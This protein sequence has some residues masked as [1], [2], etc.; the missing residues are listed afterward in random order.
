M[1]IASKGLLSSTSSSAQSNQKTPE[2]RIIEC[3]SNFTAE[4]IVIEKIKKEYGLTHKKAKSL[5]DSVVDK[6]RISSTQELRDRMILN[7][8]RTLEVFQKALEASLA[9]GDMKGA[10]W[11]SGQIHR[12]GI[13]L[14]RIVLPR[15]GIQVTAKTD[16]NEVIDSAWGKG[17]E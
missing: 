11:L 17:E 15:T 1:S 4:S 2:D 12:I 16:P 7:S 5:Y 9:A 3:I 6:I 10:V 14:G 8:S 13:D